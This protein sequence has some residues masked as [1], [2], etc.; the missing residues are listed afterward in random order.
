MTK[1]ETS[2][3]EGEEE[4]LEKQ[5]YYSQKEKENNEKLSSSNILEEQKIGEEK[6][7]REGGQEGGREGGERGLE[8]GG[9]TMNL[10]EVYHYLLYC[11][12]GKYSREWS[13]L[14]F[15]LTVIQVTDDPSFPI[16][17]FK[18]TKSEIEILPFTDFDLQNQSSDPKYILHLKGFFL[19]FFFYLF[20]F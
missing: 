12:K 14:D 11:W 16:A 19:T 18:Q 15:T 13:H 7:E 4:I 2:T 3:K 6:E 10:S 8:E 5:S 9:E 1:K 20:I 17:V